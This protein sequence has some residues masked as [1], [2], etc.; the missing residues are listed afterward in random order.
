MF[1]NGDI[2][3]IESLDGIC[4]PT[5]NVDQILGL[6]LHPSTFSIKLQDNNNVNWSFI[7]FFLLNK[8]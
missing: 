7:K 3:D 4:S 1:L 8:L 6:F 5:F 2:G